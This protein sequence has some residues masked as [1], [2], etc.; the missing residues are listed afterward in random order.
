M[1]ASMAAWRSPTA[2]VFLSQ[3]REKTVL[4][5]TFDQTKWDRIL[6]QLQS[7]A[8]TY[9]LPNRRKAIQSFARRH[10]AFSLETVLRE[11]GPTVVQ[12]GH[13]SVASSVVAPAAAGAVAPAD[14]SEE[15][16]VMKSLQN[17][18]RELNI[19]VD[20]QDGDGCTAIMY[21]AQGGHTT[22]VK[23]LNKCGAD[24]NKADK[25]GIT[26]LMYAAQNGST[27]MVELL[28]KYGANINTTDKKGRTAMMMAEE[29]GHTDT[30]G[31]IQKVI[32][33][34]GNHN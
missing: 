17:M 7:W 26:A 29:K 2:K 14:D 22:N 10:N 9:G 28:V 25:K 23:V 31:S 11:M 1:M 3:S 30:I 6:S 21:A 34:P 4:H 12:T 15:D 33:T 32:K 16:N 5:F 27:E 13:G 20:V 8:R 18:V 24:V 19:D